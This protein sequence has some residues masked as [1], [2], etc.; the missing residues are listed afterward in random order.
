MSVSCFRF[1]SVFVVTILLGS[2]HVLRLRLD[3]FDGVTKRH[4]TSRKASHG[5]AGWNAEYSGIERHFCV[6]KEADGEDGM[7]RVGGGCDW[8]WRSGSGLGKD[9]TGIKK[10]IVVKKKED[11]QGVGMEL[12]L[13][14]SRLVSR[15]R[16]PIGGISVGGSTPMTLRR[17][18]L[19]RTPRLTRTVIPMKRR[20]VPRSIRV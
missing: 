20:R 19:G 15:K 14:M 13:L 17:R 10:S 12:L 6:R 5:D 4:S 2:C 7:V 9:G 11:D 8:Q 3:S 18:R 1:T 16:K